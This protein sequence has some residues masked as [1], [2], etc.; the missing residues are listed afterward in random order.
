MQSLMRA[1]LLL[2]LTVLL[3]GCPKGGTEDPC[4]ENADCRSNRCGDCVC[5]SGPALSCALPDGGRRADA[6][7]VCLP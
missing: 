6:E 4:S 3:A 5:Q 2:S 7:C 1:L